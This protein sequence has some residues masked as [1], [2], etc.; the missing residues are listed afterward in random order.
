[1]PPETRSRQRVLTFA[2][3]GQRRRRAEQLKRKTEQPQNRLEE[4]VWLTGLRI[5]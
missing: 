1:M 2:A 5:Q 3:G 4:W